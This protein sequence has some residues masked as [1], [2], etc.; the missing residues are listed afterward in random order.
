MGMQE[1]CM[2]SKLLGGQVL[3]LTVVNC[4]NKSIVFCVLQP[5]T[6][7]FFFL[8]SCSSISTGGYWSSHEEVLNKII[9]WVGG[10]Y[11]FISLWWIIW[12]VYRLTILLFYLVLCLNW[13]FSYKCTMIALK[14]FFLKTLL[15]WMSIIGGH[16]FFQF[17]ILMDAC[18]FCIWLFWSPAVYSLYPWVAPF[19]DFE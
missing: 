17:M 1:A 6:D 8:M 3:N 7:E 15:D 19:Y 11:L 4:F 2:P 18:N 9:I 12:D 13:N 16:S 10:C 5:F 14:L